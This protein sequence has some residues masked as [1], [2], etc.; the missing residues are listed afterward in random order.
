MSVAR[1]VDVVVDDVC[2]GEANERNPKVEAPSH[3]QEVMIAVVVGLE[4]DSDVVVVATCEREAEVHERSPKVEALIHR[5]RNRKDGLMERNE[6]EKE[7]E[8][9]EEDEVCKEVEETK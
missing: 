2:E 5:R 9:V 3:R 4:I 6:E 7:N 1:A 8:R